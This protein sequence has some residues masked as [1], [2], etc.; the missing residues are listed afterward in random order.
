M[1]FF[2]PCKGITGDFPL[3]WTPCTQMMLG[4]APEQTLQAC[5]SAAA[6]KEAVPTA[7]VL[8]WIPPRS[9]PAKRCS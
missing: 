4:W 5:S 8:Q 9:F 2:C 6:G 3:V 1:D 7:V